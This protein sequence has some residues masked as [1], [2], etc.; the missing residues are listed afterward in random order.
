MAAQ[1][2]RDLDALDAATSKADWPAAQSS[3]LRVAQNELDLRLLYHRMLD[4]DRSRLALWA[5]QL[6]VDVAADDPGAVHGD[7]AALNRVWE[8]TRDTLE[9]TSAV[10]AA[11]QEL[12][13][14]ADAGD[15]PAVDRAATTLD[16]AVT[17]LHAH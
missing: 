2:R 11:L 3:A 7:V 9:P 16:R 8:R 10:D 5:R 12:R 15:L 14:A 6:P 13:R 4:V 1:M 17:Q